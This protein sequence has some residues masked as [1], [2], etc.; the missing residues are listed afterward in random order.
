MIY[1]GNVIY[2]GYNIAHSQMHNKG[3]FF[4]KD[5]T[6][7]FYDRLNQSNHPDPPNI[8]NIPNQTP[9]VSGNLFKK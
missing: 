1:A 7:T 4:D 9:Q 6:S 5:K 2:D 3:F 8:C